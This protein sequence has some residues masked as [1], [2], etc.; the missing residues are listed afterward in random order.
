MAAPLT[1]ATVRRVL[2]DH[3]PTIL[4]V[5][6]P[7]A[8]VAM[9]LT[10]GA[11]GPELLFILRAAHDRDPWSGNIGFPG[12]RVAAADGGPRHTAERESREELALDLA[13]GECLG[14]LDDLYGATLPILVS[15]YVYTVPAPMP[16]I[17][18]HEVASFFWFS[19]H[20][21]GCPERWRMATFSWRGQP[22][23]QPVMALLAPGEPLLW[24][25]TYRLLQ[26]FFALMGLPFAESHGSTTRHA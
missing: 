19:L 11:A 7:H 6:R 24:G 4:P 9:V 14:R 2:A 21:L 26:S 16:L 5:D 15:C 20:E 1:L 25:I 8:A 13:N 3:Q 23:T 10:E 22:T 17:P 18:N 12:G